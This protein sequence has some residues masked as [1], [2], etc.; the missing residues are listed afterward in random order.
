MYYDVLL[1]DLLYLGV[2]R[3]CRVLEDMSGSGTQDDS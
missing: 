3:S 2:K 1:P